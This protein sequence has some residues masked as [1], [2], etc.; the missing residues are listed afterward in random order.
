VSIQSWTSLGVRSFCL[1]TSTTVVVW[2]RICRITSA[3]RFAVH[4]CCSPIASLLVHYIWSE[5]RGG[6]YKASIKAVRAYRKP[7][8]VS[9]KP[10]IVAQNHLDRQFTVTKPD[11]AWVTDIT[12]VR[13]Y[14]G[15]LHLAVVIDLYSR[16]VVG[17]SMKPNLHR[18]IALDALIMGLR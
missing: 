3:F 15:W 16:M 4:R 13:T 9:S 17:W 14:Q 6:H 12:Y 18:D 11:E 5:Q 10:S 2:R 1:A 8:Y 7:R